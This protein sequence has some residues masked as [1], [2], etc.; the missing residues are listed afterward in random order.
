MSKPSLLKYA[1]KV[2]PHGLLLLNSS[3]VDPKEVPRNDLD[4]LPIPAN[5]IAQEMKN[6]RLANMVVIGAFVEKTKVVSLDT[7]I[8]ALPKIFDERH[9]H[10]IP[11]NTEAIRKGAEYTWIFLSKYPG[12]PKP[13]KE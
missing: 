6:D 11:A 12:Q 3:M 13:A 4:L 2:K 10:L 5:E 9:H 7:L 1:P 8:A